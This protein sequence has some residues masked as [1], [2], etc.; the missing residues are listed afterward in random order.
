MFW[1]MCNIEVFFLIRVVYV[2]IFR[3]LKNRF[4]NC[5]VFRYIV[6]FFSLLFG[7][8]CRNLRYDG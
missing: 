8:F 6:I 7:G 1:N 3:G 4:I 2:Y 5:K